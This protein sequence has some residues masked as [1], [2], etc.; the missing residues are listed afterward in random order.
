MKKKTTNII[1]KVL[2]VMG[3][4]VAICTADGSNHEMALRI[5]GLAAMAIGGYL[6]KCFD[7]QHD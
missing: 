4:F 6:G 3:T 7:F 1:G 2:F 5:A